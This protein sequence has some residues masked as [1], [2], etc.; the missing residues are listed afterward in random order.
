MTQIDALAA[1]LTEAGIKASAWRN[2]RI[3]LNGHG[4]DIKAF[5]TFDDPMTPEAECTGPMGL[6]SGCALKVYS[7]AAQGQQWLVNRAKQVKHGIMES[8]VEAEIVPGPVCES[9]QDAIL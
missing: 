8:L 1:K 9:W 2:Q 4:K 7:D 5:I 3:Y 6:F